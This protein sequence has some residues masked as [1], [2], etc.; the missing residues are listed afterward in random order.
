MTA[1]GKTAN[2]PIIVTDCFTAL[3]TGSN[4]PSQGIFA[5]YSTE[6]ARSGKFDSV[7]VNFQFGEPLDN[8]CLTVPS[9]II[10]DNVQVQV[11]T[12]LNPTKN[13]QLWRMLN[14]PSPGTVIIQWDNQG[15]VGFIFTICMNARRSF[16]RFPLH[17]V[18][19]MQELRCVFNGHYCEFQCWCILL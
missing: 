13:R 6:I 19:P 4:P 5:I 7:G 18:S 10:D 2:S 16:L 1:T 17:S 12:C 11:Q 15:K 9:G 14:G 3:P 8:M